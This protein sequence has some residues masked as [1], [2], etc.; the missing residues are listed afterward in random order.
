MSVGVP[1]S[2][3]TQEKELVTKMAEYKFVDYL[4]EYMKERVKKYLK[5][6]NPEDLPA[7]F[8]K[9]P[10]EKLAYLI[11]DLA[12]PILRKIEDDAII[13]AVEKVASL[14]RYSNKE[15]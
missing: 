9:I 6:R 5:D 2:A 14:I 11:T 15:R 12:V 3:A 4:T 1:F 7:E 13:A 8:I 10:P